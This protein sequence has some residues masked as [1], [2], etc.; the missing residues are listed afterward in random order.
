MD[1]TAALMPS[2]IEAAI[3]HTR[4]KYAYGAKCSK[5]EPNST[6]GGGCK[7]TQN[8]LRAESLK[9]PAGSSGLRR[10]EAEIRQPEHLKTGMK[11]GKGTHVKGA[12]SALII[13][14]KK[15]GGGELMT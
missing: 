3:K 11:K 7:E 15:L 9:Q 1:K 13:E 5:V 4:V 6:R 2:P 14:K 8:C 12:Q 10:E